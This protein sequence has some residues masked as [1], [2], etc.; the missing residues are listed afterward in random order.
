MPDREQ[1]VTD[2]AAH[3][4]RLWAPRLRH[5][6]LAHIDQAEGAGLS[7]VVNQAVHRHGGLL[8]A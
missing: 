2:L 8:Q 7:P 5:A 1:A 3:L 4:K 6:M